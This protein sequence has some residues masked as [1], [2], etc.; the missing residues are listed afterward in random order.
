MKLKKGLLEHREIISQFQLKMAKETEG[1]D[2]DLSIVTQG[3]EYIMNT[4]SRGGYRVVEIDNQIVGSLLILKE[5]SD[6]RC[7][8]VLWIHSV[9]IK[10]EFRRKGLFKFMYEELKR[11]VELNDNL[12]GLRL[13]V[14]KTNSVAQEVYQKLEMSKEHYELFEWLKD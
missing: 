1:M 4:P 6:W 8:D 14:D 5:W 7:K 9:Y 3:V 11:E 12:A 13:Y 2:L 10:K